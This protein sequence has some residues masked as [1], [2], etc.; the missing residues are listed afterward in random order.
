MNPM[1]YYQG[2]YLG[3]EVFLL[4]PSSSEGCPTTALSCWPFPRVI[5]TW[6]GLPFTGPLPSPEPEPA[7]HRK[8]NQNVRQAPVGPDAA[9]SHTREH[10]YHPHTGRYKSSQ[11]RMGTRASKPRRRGEWPGP[12]DQTACVVRS[13]S[14]GKGAVC[15]FW[16]VPMGK[17]QC[18][19]LKFWSKAVASP[20]KYDSPINKGRNQSLVHRCVGP[21]KTLLWIVSK[22]N[23]EK[24]PPSS[25]GLGVVHQLFV[26]WKK[27]IVLWLEYM[28]PQG[29]WQEARTIDQ[30]GA[31]EMLRKSG[32]MDLGEW[33]WGVTTTGILWNC[34]SESTQRWSSI[35]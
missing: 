13:V 8:E 2:L 25:V 17:S 16:R 10:Q 22:D 24:K 35:K 6:R 4:P 14:P 1:L 21:V 15:C 11:H 9:I 19:L 32:W 34:P 20:G 29:W 31:D 28:L 3:V 23:G 7:H 18:Q 30:G 33:A 5:L 27:K 26:L 12:L